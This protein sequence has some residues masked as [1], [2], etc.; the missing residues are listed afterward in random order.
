[1]F[2]TC[3]IVW[4]TLQFR[5]YVITSWPSSRSLDRPTLQR[6]WICSSGGFM[7]E[8]GGTDPPNLAQP[9]KILI[10]SIVISLSRCCLPNDE[11]PGHP[12][13]FFLELPL[14]LFLATSGDRPSYGAM[15]E[16]RDGPSWL[17]DDDN[18]VITLSDNNP[19]TNFVVRYFVIKISPFSVNQTPCR[20]YKRHATRL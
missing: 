4:F 20:C 7:L 16:W 9:P 11:G 3:D 13:Y 19:K 1:M 12:K 5:K 18:D 6:H 10:G 17:R 15:V 8:P 14:D 2:L